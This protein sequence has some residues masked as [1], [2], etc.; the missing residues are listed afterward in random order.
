MTSTQ[1]KR[2]TGGNEHSCSNDPSITRSERLSTSFSEYYPVRCSS[3]SVLPHQHSD[4]REHM[5]EVTL[6]C[7]SKIV[8][9][10]E[11]RIEALTSTRVY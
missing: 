2:N 3:P 5:S 11:F 4:N 9:H 10:I 6:F 8:D 7:R 1:S